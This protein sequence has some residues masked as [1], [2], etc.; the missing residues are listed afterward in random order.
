MRTSLPRLVWQWISAGV[1]LLFPPRCA[2][3][4]RL[5]VEWCQTCEQSV[6]KLGGRLCHRC[7]GPLLNRRRCP[8]CAEHPLPLTVRSH[9]FYQ[10]PLVRALLQLKYRANRR[11][12][13]IMAGWLRQ[14]YVNAGWRA[15]LVVAVPLS[16]ARLRQRGYNQAELISVALAKAVE[17]PHEGGALVRTR[18][19]A[20]QVGLGPNERR[21]NVAGAFCG[22]PEVVRERVVLVVDDLYTTGATMAACARGLKTAGACQV[23]GLTVGRA[24]SHELHSR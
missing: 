9:A 18:E 11:L 22:Q 12:A 1:D 5:G 3:C 16:A 21:R 15:D 20:S 13:A 7:G 17:L 10:G 4:G 19:T 8:S 14:I 24:G 6:V 2:G 23:L